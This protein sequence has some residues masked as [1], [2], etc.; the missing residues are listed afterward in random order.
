MY[1][2]PQAV[3][4]VNGKHSEVFAIEW[5]VRQGCPL[6]PLLHA[7]T[8]ELLLRRLRGEE[9]NPALRR[10]P[11]VGRV[12][13]KVS[14]Y[15]DDITVFVSRRFDILA[16]KK[17]VQRYEEVA[18]AKNNFDKSEGLRLGSKDTLK[19]QKVRDVFP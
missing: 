7:L 2:N 12:R 6:F 15:A 5:S 9:T 13:A 16:V 8:L 4:Q 18:G 14:A 10:V 11:F 3:V 1:H 17:A 19:E